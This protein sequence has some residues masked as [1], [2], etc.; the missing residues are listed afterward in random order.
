MKLSKDKRETSER[1]ISSYGR[2]R[3]SLSSPHIAQCQVWLKDHS[4]PSTV[5]VL[6]TL[7][8]PIIII[9]RVSALLQYHLEYFN[10][11]GH[12]IV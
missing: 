12:P 5:G 3:F 7:G 11:I 10:L 1:S 2:Q 4:A 9:F 6:E 8:N